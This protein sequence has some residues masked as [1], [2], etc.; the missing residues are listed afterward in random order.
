M[1]YIIEE[2]VNLYINLGMT[3]GVGSS[4]SIDGSNEILECESLPLGHTHSIKDGAL[5]FCHVTCE[6]EAS[7]DRVHL[8]MN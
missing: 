8:I 1:V 3:I 5:K 4:S 6:K 2:H 7:R